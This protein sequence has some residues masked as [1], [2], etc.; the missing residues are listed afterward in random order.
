[1]EITTDISEIQKGDIVIL[2]VK[3]KLESSLSST[4]EKKVFQFINEGNNKLLLD[5]NDVSYINSAG[6]RMLLSVKKKVKGL[7]GTFIVCN[8]K[9]EVMEIMKICGFDHVLDIANNEEEAM[10]KF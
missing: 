8:L 2:R 5:L 7:A 3:G 10:R 9:T 1:M 4:L 6:L